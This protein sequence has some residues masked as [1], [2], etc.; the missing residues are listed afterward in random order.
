MSETPLKRSSF[1]L[2]VTLTKAECS[3]QHSVRKNSV[4]LCV[5]PSGSVIVTGCGGSAER[6][7]LQGSLHAAPSSAA[8]LMPCQTSACWTCLRLHT[9]IGSGKSGNALR[10]Y[11]SGYKPRTSRVSIRGKC[12]PSHAEE[13]GKKGKKRH[14]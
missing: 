3:C 8:S 12:S 10:L 11:H 2:E 7:L 14:F 4:A 13:G 6:C 9:Y 5:T 1:H